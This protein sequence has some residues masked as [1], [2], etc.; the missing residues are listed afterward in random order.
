MA[1][2]VMGQACE[3]AAMAP[4]EPAVVLASGGTGPYEYS[5]DSINFF[6]SG[7][8]TNLPGGTFDFHV[9]ETFFPFIVS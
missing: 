4:S 6:A 3:M 9:V 2:E 7:F 5:M 8:F 1:V